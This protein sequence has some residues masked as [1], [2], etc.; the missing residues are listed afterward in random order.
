MNKQKLLLRTLSV[1][2]VVAMLC[3]AFSI[4]VIAASSTS[5]LVVNASNGSVKITVNGA[6][7][8]T[9]GSVSINVETGA[10]VTITAVSEKYL[11]LTD[12]FGNTCTEESSYTF[13]MRSPATYTAWFEEASGSAVIYRNNNTTNQVLASA[14]YT[15]ANSFTAH[16][17]S[18]AIKYGYEFQ[19]WDLSVDQIKAKIANGEKTVLVSP[20]YNEPAKTYTVTVQGGK[21]LETGTTSATVPFMEKITLVAN[22]PPYGCYF[23]GWKNSAGE[24]V[25]TAE[26]LYI[27]AFESNTYTA[28]YSYINTAYPSS[29]SLSL[30][31][32][33]NGAV[34]ATTQFTVEKGA[35]LVSYGLLYAKNVTYDTEKMTI[36]NVDG[37]ALKMASYTTHG[38]VLVNTLVNCSS[39]Y[40]RAFLIYTDGTSEHIIYSDT[41][42][43]FAEDNEDVVTDT[44][45]EPVVPVN[46]S[47][48]SRPKTYTL[49]DGTK[50]SAYSN[51]DDRIFEGVCKFYENSGYSLYCS[52]N[53]AGN[54]FATYTNG[55][56]LA[57]V[58]WIMS[59]NELNIVYS[60]TG[61]RNLPDQNLNITGN[62][63]T[64]V[65]Q[66]NYSS[67]EVNGMGYLVQLADGSFI[68]YDG[69]YAADVPELL[70]KAKELSPSSK[71]HIRAWI[72]THSHA[73]H[74]SAFNELA[75]NLSSY[76][77]KYSCTI[78]LD[79]FLMSPVKDSHA[80]DKYLSKTIFTDIQKF[81]S[82]KICR[83]Y[84][85]MDFTFGNLELEILF[86]A[87]EL[88]IDGNPGYFNDSSIVSRIY[89]NTPS[90][91]DTLSMIFL[92]DAGVNVANRLMA[93]YGT[94]LQSDM[95]Q[96]SHHGVEN[97]PL[98]AYKMINASILFYPCN[99]AL[100]NLKDRDADVRK[101]LR[102][103]STTKEILIRENAI[104]TRYFNPSRNPK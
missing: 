44:F 15:S 84:T 51:A 41:K 58:Y 63:K 46:P 76:E 47:T 73:D 19:G 8:H 79:Y 103:S 80:D 72:M 95:C 57:H 75:N 29:I 102:E 60:E 39:V 18:K 78:D 77:S 25:S 90:N 81:D 30:A 4:S 99:N 88:Y 97:F 98:E 43:M 83:I 42:T 32:A 68:V 55:A 36:E 82:A 48:L 59:Q 64:S 53:K 24:V 50:L 12:S 1:L 2:L 31:P 66:L 94:Y 5:K 54:L 14:T 91:G 21:I 40:A 92:G 45:K 86:T 62:Y 26:K 104:Y 33:G 22:D 49:D 20:I 93:Y 9:G 61:A 67:K 74:Y 56:I 10:K 34:Q 69:A 17:A 100:Y 87:N 96:I 85:G 16:L 89:S 6:V 27:S 28:Q 101:A 37:S 35:Y 70:T 23:L 3:G 71:I 52:S 65:T 13:T 11:F 7:K 38:G